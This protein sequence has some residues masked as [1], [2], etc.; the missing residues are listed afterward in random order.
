MKGISTI[1]AMILIVIIVVALIGLT[2]TFAVG[3]FSTTTSGA[4]EQTTA[5]TERMQKSISIVAARCNSTNDYVYFTLK[6][7]G[8]TNITQVDLSAF[9]ADTPVSFTLSP[10]PLA[11]GLTSNQMN[12]SAIAA[13]VNLANQEYTFKVSAP[14]ADVSTKVTCTA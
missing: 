1:L 4:N 7:T 12:A 13:G 2:Y 9:I 8:T 5:I 6:S 14:A 10:A 11:A 3:L